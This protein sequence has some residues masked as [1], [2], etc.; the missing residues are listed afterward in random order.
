MTSISS[1]ES[2]RQ[3]GRT[4]R[5]VSPSPD[6]VKPIGSSSGPRS[7]A[8]RFVPSTRLTAA[9]R[10]S[11]L[12]VCAGRSSVLASTAPACTVRFGQVSER[13]STKRAIAV[14]MPYGSTPR[15]NRAD[16][17][18]RRLVRATV[19]PIPT[20]ENQAISSAIVV[21][22][23]LISVSRPPMMPPSPMGVSLASQMKRSLAGE[24]AILSVER[25]EVLTVAGETDSE[26]SPAE[27]VE[28]VGVVRLGSAPASRSC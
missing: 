2:S 6:T 19:R 10:T 18:E 4:T 11:T 28:V 23:S 9:I 1:V 14:G 8:L 15:S 25:G 17:S 5:R 16:A 12:R 26:P 21:V 22:A 3:L 13:S 20:R 7:S 24:G 27:R